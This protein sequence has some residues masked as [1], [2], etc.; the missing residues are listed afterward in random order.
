MELEYYL[1]RTDLR[2]YVRAYYYFSTDRPSI[3][4]MCAELANI[5]VLLNGGGRTI[6]PFGEE[7][8]ISAAFLLGPTNGA[9]VMAVDA[10]TRVFGI[11]IRPR[12]WGVLLGISAEE[13]ADSV[14]DLSDFGGALGHSAIDEIR[15]AP[16]LTA[17]AAV[18]DR[19]FADL[20]AH[21]AG[22]RNRYPDA[23]ENWL[24]NPDD[25]DLDRLVELMDVSR[26]QT[27]RVAKQFFGAS[28]KLL[29]RKYRALRAADRIRNGVSLYSAASAGFYD[30]SHFIKE[31]KSFIGVTPGQFA[32][33]EAQWIV[34]V[35]TRRQMAPIRHPL[36]SI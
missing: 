11:G 32:A 18:A 4:P 5:R 20:F 16:N 19:Y 15:N 9:Y 2:N 31:F 35:Q 30:Q 22:R 14:F 13:A 25:L 10:G 27:D 8:E 6:N 26:R 36:A 3:Q 1:P 28:P 24:T 29:Q 17:M 34:E 12:G 7:S 33:Q 21:R 23:L